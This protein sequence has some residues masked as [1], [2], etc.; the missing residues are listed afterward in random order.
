MRR[1][2]RPPS[3][4]SG[5]ASDGAGFRTHGERWELIRGRCEDVLPALPAALFDACIADPPYGLGIASWDFDVPG[6]DVW[7]EVLRVMKPGAWMPVFAGRRNYDLVAGAIRAAGFVIVDMGIWV[8]RN[9]SRPPSRNHLRPAHEGIVIARAPGKPIAVNRDAGRVPW[10]DEEDKRQASRVDALRA[11]GKRKALYEVSLDAYG[12]EPFAANDNG[13]VPC[14]VMVTGEDDVL[15]DDT[16]VWRVPVVRNSAGHKCAKPPELLRQLVAM[17]VPEGGVMLDPF[18][19]A[20][21]VGPIVEE[22]GRRAVLIE[23]AK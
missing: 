19:G 10:R 2:G 15:G 23:A 9:G 11:A 22:M 18:A 7:D 17:F 20:G 1:D 12:K 14:T 16:F 3:E 4:N 8:F 21:T 5:E 6:P 13:R